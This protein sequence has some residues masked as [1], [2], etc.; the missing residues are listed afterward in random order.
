MQPLAYNHSLCTHRLDVDPIRLTTIAH[1]FNYRVTVLRDG[2][3]SAAQ[4]GRSRRVAVRILKD[5][6]IPWGHQVAVMFQIVCALALEV[7]SVLQDIESLNGVSPNVSLSCEPW[8]HTDHTGKDCTCLSSD[9][10]GAYVHGLSLVTDRGFRLWM[11]WRTYLPL[12]VG[13]VRRRVCYLARAQGDQDRCHLYLSGQALMAA[14]SWLFTCD[15]RRAFWWRL[16]GCVLLRV[17]LVG[18]TSHRALCG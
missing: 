7:T 14:C 11:K 9:S 12:P 5:I 17:G 13:M 16:I 18:G 2:V 6:G 4:V 8:G 10:T 15:E 3:K 1:V